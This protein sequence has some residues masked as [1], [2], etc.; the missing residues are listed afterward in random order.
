MM[1]AQLTRCPH[2]Q[3]C[4]SVTESELSYAYGVARCGA[5]LKIFNASHHL[6]VLECVDETSLNSSISPSHN[7]RADKDLFGDVEETVSPAGP[8]E[9]HLADE[10]HDTELSST[11]GEEK[12][13][14][15][16]QSWVPVAMGLSLLVLVILVIVGN[17]RMLSQH[18]SMSALVDGICAVTGCDHPVMSDFDQLSYGQEGIIPEGNNTLQIDFVLENKGQMTVPFPAILV[19]LKDATG[20]VVTEYI[21][22]PEEYLAEMPFADHQ[23]PS[24]LPVAVTLTVKGDENLI[25]SFRLVF[26]PSL[27]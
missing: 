1:D 6:F 4:F 10:H 16:E 25:E 15:M 20:S 14:L 11:D 18:P 12:R 9:L 13:S 8:P 21:A 5:C 26:I 24:E 2:C 3:A 22:Q 7:H 27:N 23:L 17:T 19:E